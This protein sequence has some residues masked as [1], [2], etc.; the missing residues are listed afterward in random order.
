[1]SGTIRRARAADGAAITSIYLRSTARLGFL[2]KRHDAEDMARHFGTLVSRQPVWLACVNGQAEGFLALTTDH[3][4]HLYIHPRAQGLGL[5]RRLL[6][7]A[8]AE[9][10]EGFSLWTFCQN[11]AAR[12]FY[13]RSGLTIRQR[14][15][16]SRNEEKL[17]DL[18]YVWE[19]VT[20]E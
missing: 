19:G 17:P 14:T 15:D 16:G 9:L 10:P 7:Q 1:M 3:I 18:L 13:E 12:R 8:K 11:H 4:D 20:H 5:G 2:P 6:A